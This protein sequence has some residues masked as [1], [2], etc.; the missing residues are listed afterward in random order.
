MCTMC[1][2][3]WVYVCLPLHVCI[4][5]YRVQ[6]VRVDVPLSSGGVAGKEGSGVGVVDDAIEGRELEPL[7]EAVL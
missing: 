2:Y 6:G 3:L 5:T 7:G 4:C 1:T